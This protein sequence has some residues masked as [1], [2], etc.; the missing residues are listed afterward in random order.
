MKRFQLSLVVY[1]IEF[2][3][4]NKVQCTVD[5]RTIQCLENC[6][7]GSLVFRFF[8]HREN[9]QGATVDIVAQQEGELC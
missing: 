5:Y 9:V 1:E 4:C 2:V 3:R 7:S 8:V 6:T